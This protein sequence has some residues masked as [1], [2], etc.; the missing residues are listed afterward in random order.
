MKLVCS[1]DLSNFLTQG[2]IIMKDSQRVSLGTA[3]NTRITVVLCDLL[4]RGPE[5]E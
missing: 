4:L 2:R 5:H 1:D 3:S